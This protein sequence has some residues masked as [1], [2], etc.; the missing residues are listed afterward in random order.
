MFDPGRE[1][2]NLETLG[3]R[4]DVGEFLDLKGVKDLKLFLKHPFKVRNEDKSL[5]FRYTQVACPFVV[6]SGS[7]SKLDPW[8]VPGAKVSYFL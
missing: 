8:K 4:G 3:E 1:T 6:I 2:S 7:W 5:F